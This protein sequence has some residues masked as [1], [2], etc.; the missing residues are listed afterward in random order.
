MLMRTH[1][2]KGFTL[3]ELMMAVAILGVIAAIALPTYKDSIRKSKRQAAISDMLLYKQAQE[4]YRT[5]KL[6]YAELSELTGTY[7]VRTS[8]LPT[9]YVFTIDDGAGGLPT[10]TAY[11]IIATAQGSQAEGAEA[12]CTPLTLNQQDDRGP[13]PHC[14]AR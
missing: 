6:E 3:I 5:S 13:K 7:A 8:S 10:G 11:R 4:R 1:K 9:D 14:W 2:T 12:D